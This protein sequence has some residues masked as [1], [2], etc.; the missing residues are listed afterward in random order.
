MDAAGAA[1][2]VTVEGVTGNGAYRL[3]AAL[4]DFYKFRPVFGATQG[5]DRVITY[6]L[7]S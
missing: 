6:F 1:A 5:D 4:F 7:S 2:T 3:P